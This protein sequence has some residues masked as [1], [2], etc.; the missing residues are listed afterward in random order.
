LGQ[1]QTYF[2]E[3]MEKLPPE[4]ATPLWQAAQAQATK[5]LESAMPQPVCAAVV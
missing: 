2:V 1:K 4:L 5:A 3:L